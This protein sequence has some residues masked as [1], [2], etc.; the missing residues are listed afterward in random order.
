[1]VNNVIN[2]ENTRSTLSAD[3]ELFSAH[4][5]IHESG[6]SIDQFINQPAIQLAEN[7]F[8]KT[9]SHT[10]SNARS[11]PRSFPIAIKKAQGVFV[12]DTEDQIFIDCLAGAGTFALGHN[13]PD[14]VNAVTE[15]ISTGGPWQTLDI[16]SPAKNNFV[17]EVYKILP[18]EFSQSAKLQFC[19]P[20]GTDAMEAAIKL[21]K[22][23]TGRSGIWS[24]SGAYHGMTNGTLALMGNINT[25]SPVPGLMAD[26]QFMPF[27]YEYRCP[28]GLTGAESIKANLNY[29]EHQLS[30]QHSGTPLPAAIVV[31]AIQG[32]GGV[33]P[34]PKEWLQGLREITE[35]HGVLLILDEI[36][37]GIGR[38]G[39]MFA[40]EIADINP[41]VIAMSKAVGGGLPMALIA[42]HEKLDQW[43]PGAHTGTFRGNQLAMISG[44]KTLKI[45]RETNLI[46]SVKEKGQF[47]LESLHNLK[48]DCDFIGDIRGRGLMI[49]IEIVDTQSAGKSKAP[50]PEL[51]TKIQQ[52]CLQQGLILETGGR[53]GATIRFL[54]PLNISQ[55]E[56]K[57]V[58]NI[59][60]SSVA[61][62][63]RKM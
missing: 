23:T 37:C 38:S 52:Q 13:H 35:R 27:P 34:A 63:M 51:A 43:K 16:T 57:T 29:L 33:I 9:Q 32:E 7:Q 47:L 55:E 1:M 22:I 39:D 24:F 11:Y 41:D 46:E 4:S 49:G 61:E 42:Y 56:L 6:I 31:E 48:S 26:V 62:V 36:Q 14:V 18:D 21:A 54:P 60:I 3:N 2:T 5:N 50:N 17:S 8:L 59:F 58:T 10:E 12:Q 53:S 15:Y 28:F 25:K 19:G 40:F 44:A 20:A 45:L 30:D